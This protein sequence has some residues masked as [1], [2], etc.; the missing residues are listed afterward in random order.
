MQLRVA[1]HVPW[2]LQSLPERPSLGRHRA[3]PGPCPGGG[4]LQPIIPVPIR[5]AARLMSVWSYVCGVSQTEHIHLL[6]RSSERR[7][8]C[9]FVLCVLFLQT[10][11]IL[12]HSFF[13]FLCYDQIK[14]LRGLP[15]LSR[16]GRSLHYTSTKLLF[17]VTSSSH[18]FNVT[19]VRL[20]GPVSVAFA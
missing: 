17:H 13:C 16:L 5:S 18:Q 7:T 3:Q 2:C 14:L 8:A 20:H 11:S 15:R 9:E 19:C 4:T 10:Y 12:Q 1:P 6:V